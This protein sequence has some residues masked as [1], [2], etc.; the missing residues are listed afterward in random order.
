MRNTL[1]VFAAVAIALGAVGLADPEDVS[2]VSCNAGYTQTSKTY[3]FVFTL[4]ANADGVIHTSSYRMTATGCYK[5]GAGATYLNASATVTHIGG[6][7]VPLISNTSGYVGTGGLYYEWRNSRGEWSEFFGSA[8]FVMRMR[9]SP[10]GAWSW[11]ATSISCSFGLL[12]GS[13]TKN[14]ST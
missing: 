10:S 8:N 4:K 2:A 13:C 11:T 9:L 14:A 1:S 6:N 12:G 3:N 5:S 7:V